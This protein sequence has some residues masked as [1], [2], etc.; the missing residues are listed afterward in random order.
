MDKAIKD[1]FGS[2]P[3]RE[4]RIKL[5][6]PTLSENGYSVDL[7]VEAESPMSDDDFVRQIA[8]FSER[9]PIPLI[10]SYH[11][12]PLSGRAELSSKIR[13]GGT[14]I[15]HAIAEMSDGSL[16]KTST[17]VYVTLAACV[18]G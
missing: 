12:T 10:A 16:W 8:V 13:L 11:F 7:K 5:S 9:N 4:G 3:I 15:V 18:T 17:K 2:A 14:Q 1:M 6:I